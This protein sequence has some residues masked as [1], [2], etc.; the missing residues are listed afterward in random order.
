MHASRVFFGVRVDE[1][2]IVHGVNGWRLVEYDR[3]PDTGVGTFTY[4]RTARGNVETARE[5]RLQPSTPEHL[6]W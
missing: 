3:N 2:A 4:E 6:G 1:P 5:M